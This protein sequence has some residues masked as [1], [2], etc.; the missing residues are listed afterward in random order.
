MYLAYLYDA[1]KNFPT[2][3]KPY[4]Y[5]DVYVKLVNRRNAIIDDNRKE[6]KH[7]RANEYVCRISSE[8]DSRDGE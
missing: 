2:E 1:F 7:K 4:E 6:H 5:E 3:S 8:K